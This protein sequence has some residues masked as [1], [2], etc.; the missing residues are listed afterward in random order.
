MPFRR[1][2]LLFLAAS[3]LAGGTSRALASPLTAASQPDLRGA[4]DAVEYRAVPESGDRKT[5]NLEQMIKQAAA[6]NV[7]VFLP[8]GTYKVSNL[9][10]PDNTRISGVP[11]ASRIVYTG[12]G[13][14]FAAE[15]IGRIELSNLVID[16]GNRWLGDY[17]GG[18][19]QFTGIDEVLID[20]C[21]IGGSRKHG[22]QL[23][24]CGG[25]IERSRISGA[26]QSGLYAVDSTNLSIVA[27]TVSDCGNGGIL[28]HRWKK[29][30]DGTVVSG[31]RIFNIRAN[32]GGTGQNGNGINVFRADG[33]MV[34]NNHI[35]DC[36][37]TAIRANSASNIQISSNQCRR[38]GETAIYVEFAFEGAVVSANMIDGAAN[39]ISIANF[40]EGGRLASVTGNVVRNLTLKGPYKHEVGFGIG[41]AA[42]ADTLVSGNVIEGAPRWGLQ[43]GWGAYLRNVVVSGNVVRKAPVGCAV[44]VAEGAGTAVITD[45]IFQEVGEGAVLGFEWDRQVSAEMAG[46]NAPYA[47]LT[48]ERNRVS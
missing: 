28:V 26:A 12:D 20:N 31:N 34:V 23:E 22:L 4:I 19:L 37:F 2:M 13:H 33:V 6:E 9:T 39:G 27:N 44:S 43:I 11:G 46:G 47:Q 45:N 16:G 8:P 36:A 41:I 30:E 21:E 5:R 29:A 48:V 1:D 3:A 25:R 7:P 14:L 40:D 42:E 17:A 18:L 38:S 24:R 35:S 15:N 10:L 32:D